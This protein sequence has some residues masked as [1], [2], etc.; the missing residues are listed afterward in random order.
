MNSLKKKGKENNNAPTI[1]STWS[2]TGKSAPGFNPNLLFTKEP[3][4]SP[5]SAPKDNRK[6][7]WK[8]Y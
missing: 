1:K 8:G 6:P 2:T 3:A 5:I 7:K 4:K